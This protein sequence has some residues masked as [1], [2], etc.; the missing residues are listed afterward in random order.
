MKQS[1]SGAWEVPY[2]P[3]D[4]QDVGRSYEAV[5]RINSQSGKGGIAYIL[6]SEYGL[7]LPRK[8]QVSFSQKVQEQADSSGKEITPQQLW[9]LFEANYLAPDRHFAR[10][11]HRAVPDTHATADGKSVVEVKCVSESV[12]FGG[13]RHIKKKK[14]ATKP[15]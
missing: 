11:E 1:N 12:A 5:V 4:P 14:K 3:I 9:D 13:G 10:V 15:R 2:L 8:L 7:D 6:H